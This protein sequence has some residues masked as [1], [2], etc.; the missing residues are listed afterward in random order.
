MKKF[1]A[2]IMLLTGVL[3][4]LPSYATWYCYATNARQSLH[5]MHFNASEATA[6]SLALQSCQQNTSATLNP[7]TCH[8]T[9]CSQAAPN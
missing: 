6:Q 9:F 4:S 7:A 3:M 5:W 8:I 2:A 1:I